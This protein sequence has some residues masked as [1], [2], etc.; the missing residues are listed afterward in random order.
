[1]SI[2]VFGGTILAHKGTS[3][4]RLDPAGVEASSKGAPPLDDETGDD[5][6][7]AEVC[8]LLSPHMLRCR[9]E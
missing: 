6:P 2:W 4:N 3:G 7:D 9:V 1:M 5:P 8:Q